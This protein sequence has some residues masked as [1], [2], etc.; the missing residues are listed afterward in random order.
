[1]WDHEPTADELLADR[2]T[3]GWRPT[4]SPLVSGG[5]VLGHA[6]TGSGRPDASSF[7]NTENGEFHHRA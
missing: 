1:M 6:A 2:M 7:E 3:Q 4:P 5:T